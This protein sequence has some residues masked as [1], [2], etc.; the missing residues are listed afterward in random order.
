[1]KCPICKKSARC[2]WSDRI[3]ECANYGHT[4]YWS[5]K[6]NLIV[7]ELE[8][9]ENGKYQYLK[10]HAGRPIVIKYNN[11]PKNLVPYFKINISKDYS[12]A[13]NLRILNEAVKK[14]KNYRNFL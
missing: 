10:S 2:I 13:K 8:K 6:I 12:P 11:Q 9:D 1:M 14:A 4:F 5:L 7:Y 3:Y